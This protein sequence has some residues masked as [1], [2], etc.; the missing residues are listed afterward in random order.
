MLPS[1]S[2]TKR[3]VQPYASC[4]AP[5]PTIRVPSGQ[6]LPGSREIGAVRIA[7]PRPRVLVTRKVAWVVARWLPADDAGAGEADRATGDATAGAA[8][9]TVGVA[10]GG[11]VGTAATA[12]WAGTVG[13]APAGSDAMD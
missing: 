2:R 7:M 13:A 5:S 10:G 4:S 11:L 1:G 12:V 8:T 6:T 9:T 3:Q